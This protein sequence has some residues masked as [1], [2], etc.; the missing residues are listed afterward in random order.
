M[1]LSKI[2]LKSCLK[3]IMTLIAMTGFLYQTS[4]LIK[5]YWSGNTVASITVSLIQVDS[6][7]AVTICTDKFLPMGN[8]TDYPEIDQESLKEYNDAVEK[9]SGIEKENT[10]ERSEVIK[11]IETIY[12]KIKEKIRVYSGITA[13][14]LLKLYT[15]DHRDYKY[16]TSIFKLRLLGTVFHNGEWINVQSRKEFNNQVPIDSI[17]T[18]F[19][20]GGLVEKCFTFYSHLDAFWRDVDIKLDV[21]VVHIYNSTNWISKEIIDDIS[22]S[23][24][25]P[26]TLPD[27]RDFIVV[28]TDKPGNIQF[29]HVKTELLG[30][31]FDTNCKIYDLDYIHANFNMR[32]DCITDCLQKRHKLCGGEGLINTGDMFREEFLKNNDHLKL[33]RSFECQLFQKARTD[34][35][36]ECRLDCNFGYYSMERKDLS[37]DKTGTRGGIY[38]VLQHSS[39]P[40]F[41]I[42]YS[43]Q[44][45]FITFVCSFGGLLGM[46]LG[47]SLLTISESSLDI[48]SSNRAN[49]LF[50]SIFSTK[51]FNIFHRNS[52]NNIF[53]GFGRIPKK[54]PRRRNYNNQ[55]P[56]QIQYY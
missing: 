54:K 32:S 38:F 47:L 27:Q 25:S 37:F 2:F 45:S 3:I 17:L 49:Y 1:A 33:D 11:N 22:V 42:K 41:I 46:W 7:P 55:Y 16:N 43:P 26:N 10:A 14:D 29:S 9:L 5:D 24:H 4:I 53:L 36:K 20:Y 31:E 44:V 40:D 8:A 19:R 15:I 52:Y 12:G 18:R 23:L 28:P 48:L 35:Y 39:V 21:I 34:C 13:Y 30:E 51:I 56:F 50:K 6:L